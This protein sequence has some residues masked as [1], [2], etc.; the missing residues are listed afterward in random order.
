MTEESKFALLLAAAILAARK[1]AEQE[2][3][4]RLRQRKSVLSKQPFA[5]LPTSERS[6]RSGRQRRRLLIGPSSPATPLP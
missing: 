5:T 2:D 4:D 1:L 3:P 6:T